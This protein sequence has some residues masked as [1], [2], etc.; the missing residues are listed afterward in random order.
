MAEEAV[1]L[2]FSNA[3][4]VYRLTN[5]IDENDQRRCTLG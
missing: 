5:K 4:S 3:W 1:E 2:A